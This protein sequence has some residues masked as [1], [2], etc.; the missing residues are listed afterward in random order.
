MCDAIHVPRLIYLLNTTIMI[1]Q[2]MTSIF[3]V[4]LD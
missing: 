3:D 2:H 1:I 4:V